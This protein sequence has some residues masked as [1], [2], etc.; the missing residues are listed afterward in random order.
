MTVEP[1]EIRTSVAVLKRLRP[2]HVE[3]TYD[4]GCVLSTGALKEVQQA[5]RDLMGNAPYCM[6]SI[7]P[8][9]VDYELSAMNV[10]HLAVDRK[11]GALLAIAV[12]VHANMME[13]V[14]KLY[15]S[16]YPQLSRIKVTPDEAEARGWLS[17]Q[18]KELSRTG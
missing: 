10:D 13:M 2:D 6:L 3:V 15:F 16:Y 1:R 5:R 7:I 11:E 4:P 8:E 14:L 9:D 12:V 18:M 17:A